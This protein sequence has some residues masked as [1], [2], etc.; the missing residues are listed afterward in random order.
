M[1]EGFFDYEVTAEVK[2]IIT[3]D[4]PSEAEEEAEM[5]LANI[6]TDINIISVE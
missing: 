6:C 4:T 3:A 1:P 2:L 5:E